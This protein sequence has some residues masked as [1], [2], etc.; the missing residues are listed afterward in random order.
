MLF[1]IYVDYFLETCLHLL[2]LEYICPFLEPQIDS[3]VIAKKGK[4][5]KPV[6]LQWTAII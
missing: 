6:E 1:L 2:M 5:D 3:G 4:K